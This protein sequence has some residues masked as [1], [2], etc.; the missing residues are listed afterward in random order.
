[1][2]EAPDAG[3]SVAAALHED[4]D[5]LFARYSV[6]QMES[7]SAELGRVAHEKQHAARALVG[8]RYQELLGVAKTV[9]NMQGSLA[10]L[11]TSLQGLQRNVCEDIQSWILP[12]TPMALHHTHVGADEEQGMR[13]LHGRQGKKNKARTGAKDSRGRGEATRTREEEQWGQT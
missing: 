1:M 5:G 10:S 3:P 11:Q 4:A 7:Y 9:V 13:K 12:S 2:T 6:K 8:D